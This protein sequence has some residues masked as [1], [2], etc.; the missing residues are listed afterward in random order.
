MTTQTL[1]QATGLPLYASDGEKV[2]DVEAVFHD[3]AT[4]RPEWLAIGTGLLG[5]KRLLVPVTS[6]VVRD[7][8]I[9]VPYGAGEIQATP[10]VE[11]DEVSQE[12][13]RMLYSHYRIPYSE[14]KSP[15]GLP[16]DSSPEGRRGTTPA[17]PARRAR[18]AGSEPT[19]KELYEEA[20]RLEIPGRSKMNKREL[21]RAVDRAGGREGR[22]SD[23]ETTKAN[24]IEVQRFLEGVRYPTGRRDLLGE[25]RR[26]GAGDEV[27]STLERLPDER[28]ETPTDVSE[29]IGKLS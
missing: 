21:A 9:E 23:E 20:R 24:P 29:A 8:R 3:K 26:Q 27:R 11:G 10:Q 22:R 5:R 19:R 4:G 6:A 12:T 17:E 18:R 16:A 14:Q 7:D 1:E 13:E 15:S 25:A 2:G 28:F